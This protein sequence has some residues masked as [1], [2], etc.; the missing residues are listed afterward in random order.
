LQYLVGLSTLI[1]GYGWF[2]VHNRQ[3]SYKS[4]MHITISR[5]QSVLYE[6]K[7]FDLRRWEDLIEE[8]NKLRREIKSVAAEYDVDWDE[9]QDEESE[10][11]IK[12]LKAERE[13]K[14]EGKKD[15]EKDDSDGD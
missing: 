9:A 14:K 6:Q 4:A 8:G 13:K 1:G 12:A 15:D 11:V 2:L 3:A 7:G 10:K 5:R